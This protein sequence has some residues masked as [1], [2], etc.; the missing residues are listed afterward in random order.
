MIV[1]LYMFSVTYN[2]ECGECMGTKKLGICGEQCAISMKESGGEIRVTPSL[3]SLCPAWNNFAGH[4]HSQYSTSS[5]VSLSRFPLWHFSF[6][7]SPPATCY[8]PRNQPYSFIASFIYQLYTLF[9]FS[10]FFFK[11]ENKA[12]LI[13]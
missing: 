2:W 8:L 11:N 10:P 13:G 1:Q 5:H 7:I 6:P 12:I 4:L 9:F 3:S